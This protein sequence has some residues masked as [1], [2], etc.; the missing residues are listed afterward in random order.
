ML[1]TST[2]LAQHGI[3]TGAPNTSAALDVVSSNKGVLIPRIALTALN[4]LSPITGTVSP[5]QNGPL[6]Y[7][8]TTTAPLSEGFYVW[9]GTQANG[10]GGSWK[11]IVENDRLTDGDT[12]T[13]ILVDKGKAQ[14]RWLSPQKVA[15][16]AEATV[17]T[18]LFPTPQKNLNFITMKQLLLIFTKTPVLGQVKT[19][20]AQ[21]VG[22]YR[23]LAIHHLL[24]EKTLE[25]VHP[26]SVHKA[27]FFS[28]ALPPKTERLPEITYYQQQHGSNLGERMQAAFDWGFKKG[29]QQ[30]VIIGTDLWE[31]ETAT[32]QEAF[33]A[34][35][36]HKTV[37]GP[38]TDG[39]Y[40]LLGLT[41]P[42]PKLFIDKQWGWGSVLEATLADLKPEKPY[43]LPKKTD[44]DYLDDLLLF[45]DLE[46]VLHRL[47]KQG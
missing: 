17:T 18:P 35:A 20:L 21:A 11:P 37:I 25:V 36:S 30:I 15:E 29:Y 27:L 14:K 42:N 10:S 38:A 5:S 33:T 8:T 7:N 23:A 6:V 28:A 32:L 39:G 16:P 44:I 22:N 41:Q 12:D 26:L 9:D 47:P 19:R 13:K 40:Y 34:L 1:G 24:V 46:Q 45:P 4:S 31:L 2:A 43:T 3:G